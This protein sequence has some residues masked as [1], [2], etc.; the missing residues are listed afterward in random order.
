M[1]ALYIPLLAA[2]LVLPSAT[3][4]QTAADETTLVAARSIRAKTVIGEGDVEPGP[5]AVNGAITEPD[6]I[7]GMET[8]R[9]LQRGRPIMPE[10]V[11][12]PAL[13]E[14]NQVVSM[15][16]RRGA[17]EIVTE[18]RALE[19][20]GDGDRIRVMNLDSRATVTATVTGPGLVEVR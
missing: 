9:W 4:A 14:R 7:I 13:V 19:R 18:G 5:V 17:L 11:G 10:D 3:G 16:F 1:R 12:P 2:L 8:R 6:D 20:A 15:R